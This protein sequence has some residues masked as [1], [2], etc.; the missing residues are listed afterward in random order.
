M[1]YNWVTS[2]LQAFLTYYRTI[3]SKTGIHVIVKI[4]LLIYFFVSYQKNKYSI[5]V[6]YSII[7]N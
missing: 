1:V 7:F 4:E 6:M 2:E 5:F 3:Y